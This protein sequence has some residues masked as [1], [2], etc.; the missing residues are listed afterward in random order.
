MVL[1]SIVVFFQN[2]WHCP[3]LM[4]TYTICIYSFGRQQTF[5]FHFMS[6]C[7]ITDV[8]IRSGDSQKVILS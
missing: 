5:Y 7:D 1:P 4:S 6:V 8:I 3:I 2:R